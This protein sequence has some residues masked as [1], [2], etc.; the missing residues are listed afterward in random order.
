MME[1]ILKAITSHFEESFIGAFS[2]DSEL[3]VTLKDKTVVI[4]DYDVKTIMD[5]IKEIEEA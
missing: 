4:K 5:I 1:M 3:T 2:H